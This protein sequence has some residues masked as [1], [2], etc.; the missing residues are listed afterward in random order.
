VASASVIAAA[1]AQYQQAADSAAAAYGI[2]APLFENLIGHESS[3]QPYAIGT[4]GEVGLTQLMPG[5]AA[6][7]GVDPYDTNANLAGGAAFLAS[8]KAKYGSWTKALSAYNAGTPDSAAGQSY[9]AV[10]LSGLDAATGM[11]AGSTGTTGDAAPSGGPANTFLDTLR[12]YLGG[13]EPQPTPEAMAQGAGLSPAPGSSSSLT[14]GDAAAWLAKYGITLSIAV[15]ALLIGLYIVGSH[16][17]GHAREFV[18][19]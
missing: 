14:A 11:P 4:S 19:A 17:V 15:G 16:A 3:W 1:K 13:Y 18:H 6:A 7:L 5:T 12:H 10:V 9:A 8:L 2:P